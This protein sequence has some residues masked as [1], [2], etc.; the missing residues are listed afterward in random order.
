MTWFKILDE[1]LQ[2]LGIC[3][4]VLACLVPLVAA[5][6]LCAMLAVWITRQVI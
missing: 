2:A 3:G 6:W 4:Y 1:I 5:A